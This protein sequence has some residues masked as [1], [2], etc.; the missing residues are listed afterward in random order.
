MSLI[1]RDRYKLEVELISKVIIKNYTNNENRI[2]IYELC[3]ALNTPNMP[4]FYHNKKESEIDFSVLQEA[5]KLN[6]NLDSIIKN[7]L[8]FNYEKFKKETHFTGNLK[9]DSLLNSINESL[10][11]STFSFK[12]QQ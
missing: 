1:E 2:K 9:L 4:S 12:I 7:E 8:D 3:I 6:D 11:P 10:K 5:K